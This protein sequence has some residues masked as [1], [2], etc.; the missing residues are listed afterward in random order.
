MK[1]T[2]VKSLRKAIRRHNAFCVRRWPDKYRRLTPRECGELARKDAHLL[3][4]PVLKV[5]DF[6]DTRKTKSPLVTIGERLYTMVPLRSLGGGVWAMFYPTRTYAEWRAA[7]AAASK[8][9]DA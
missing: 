9:G 6:G 8:G 1:R 7:A 5:F 4:G 2:W 3:T